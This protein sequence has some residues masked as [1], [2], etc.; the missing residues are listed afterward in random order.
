MK[1]ILVISL[2]SFIENQC[3]PPA[4]V[5]AEYSSWKECTIAALEIS[6]E[7]IIAQEDTFVNDN[8]VATQFVCK[9]L[10]QV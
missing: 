2:C 1:F 4:Q 3:L 7:I 5:K 9:E 8:R 6:K 10:E